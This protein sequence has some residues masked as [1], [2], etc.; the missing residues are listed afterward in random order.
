MAPALRKT[1]SSKMALKHV[2]TGIKHFKSGDLMSAV[3][4]FQQVRHKNIKDFEQ[5]PK[6]ELFQA[7]KID[8][9][10]VEAL[11][12]RGALFANNTKLRKAVEDFEKA[13][14]IDPEHKNAKKY[15]CET[16]VAL[17]KEQEENEEEDEALATYERVLTIN[18]NHEEAQKMIRKIKGIPEPK[19]P[20]EED[21]EKEF[22][23]DFKYISLTGLSLN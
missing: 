21:L 12:A 20:D 9:E 18:L 11:V 16:L 1:Q 13:L 6:R 4:C 7:L 23:F 8:P 5:E 14:S 17:G 15:M 2:S 10:N 3:Q 22:G 19:P